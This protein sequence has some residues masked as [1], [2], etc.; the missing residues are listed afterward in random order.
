[1]SLPHVEL[2]SEDTILIRFADQ[3]DSS[4]PKIISAAAADLESALGASL[5]DLVPSYTTLLLVYDPMSVD[6]RYV[7]SLINQRV[8]GWQQS[9]RGE[10]LQPLK[11]HQPFESPRASGRGI[12]ELPVYYSTESGPDLAAVAEHCGITVDDVIELHSGTVYQVYASGFSPGF[13]FMGEVPSEIRCPRHRSPRSKV[14]PGSVAIADSQT[15]VYPSAT[16]GGWQLIGHC[17]TRFF[18]EENL[19]L[20]AIGDQVRFIPVS[21]EEHQ[22]LE[23]SRRWP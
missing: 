20:L 12:I 17:P 22:K 16:P 8:S 1:M 21:R 14:P 15:A 5:L 18:D 9:F 23:R 11:S 10:S 13:A 2:L 4:L 6:F 3:I 7:R 19:S